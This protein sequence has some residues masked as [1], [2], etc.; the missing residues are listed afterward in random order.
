MDRV[1]ESMTTEELT[2]VWKPT[3]SIL[4]AVATGSSTT[5]EVLELVAEGTTAVAV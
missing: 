1:V 5:V 4:S 2:L 3:D